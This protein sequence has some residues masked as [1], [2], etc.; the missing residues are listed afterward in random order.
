MDSEILAPSGEKVSFSIPAFRRQQLLDGAD[1]IELSLRREKFI[2][3][4]H[5]EV[6]SKKPWRFPVNT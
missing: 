4:Y 2:D 6:Q 5:A 1:E 3:A